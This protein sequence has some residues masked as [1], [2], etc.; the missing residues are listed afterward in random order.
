MCNQVIHSFHQ[1]DSSISMSVPLKLLNST[2]RRQDTWYFFFKHI[3]AIVFGHCYFRNSKQLMP[4]V[5]F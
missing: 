2:Q 1:L 4:R 3:S 5:S